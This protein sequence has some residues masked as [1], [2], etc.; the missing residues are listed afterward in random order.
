MLASH[1]ASRMV[2]SDKFFSQLALQLSLKLQNATGQESRLAERSVCV[3]IWSR[4]H[5]PGL[6]F[7]IGNDL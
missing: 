6:I 7:L 2:Q 5:T 3:A 1:V 4:Y